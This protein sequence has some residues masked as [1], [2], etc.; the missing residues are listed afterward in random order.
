MPTR[1]QVLEKLKNY[2]LML[3]F[4]GVILLSSIFLF[5]CNGNGNRDTLSVEKRDVI[6]AVEV[7]GR[8]QAADDIDLSF[9]QPGILTE[10]L[11]NVNQNVEKGQKLA[12]IANEELFAQRQ[13]AIA[14]VANLNAQLK[15]YQA[16]VSLEQAQLLKA[17]SVIAKEQITLNDLRS[18]NRQED[19]DIAQ[20]SVSNAERRLEDAKNLLANTEAETDQLLNN[21]YGNAPQTLESALSTTGDVL[22]RLLDDFFTGERNFTAKLDFSSSNIS[23]VYAAGPERNILGRA[24]VDFE[25]R[26]LFVDDSTVID[27]NIIDLQNFLKDIRSHL[28]TLDR[29]LDGYE[30]EQT[31]MD[32][33]RTDLNSARTNINTQQTA[34]VSL[35]QSISSRKLEN[36]R[37]VSQ[38][39]D[40]V[41]LAE[42]TLFAAQDN[43]KL[44]QAGATPAQILKQEATLKT[45]EA[46]LQTQ[47]ARIQQ[48]EANVQSQY[49]RI[50][51]A[52]ANVNRVN[53]L[54]SKTIINAPISGIITRSDFTEGEFV[55]ASIPVIAMISDSQFEIQVDVPEVDIAKLKVGNPASVTLDAYA[56]NDLFT[57]SITEIEIAARDENGLPR[58][59]VTLQFTEQDERVKT[60][61]TANL[62]IESASA[63]SVI[64][65][66]SRAIDE[67]DGKEFVEIILTEG[68]EAKRQEVTTGLVG[69]DGFV[70]ISTGLEAGNLILLP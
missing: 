2:K 60:G 31:T 51:Q 63:L 50:S 57:A 25:Q 67:E 34:L 18:G 64:A 22:D 56:K 40:G 70:E 6:M 42:N 11:V 41:T 32:G 26:N 23:E 24:L 14:N 15:Q 8:V 1:K 61:M 59:R 53:A 9:D 58:Y 39:S 21:L 54:I 27:Q 68:A 52:R 43:L 12:V 44:I 16:G 10:L 62:F 36:D 5:G 20:V 65:I 38:A 17:E 35:V 66:P 30:T 19:L 29:A 55:S 45:V 47:K 69:S 4:A 33:Y 49:A 7:S 28:L 37:L 3:G 46:D 13:D 48:A